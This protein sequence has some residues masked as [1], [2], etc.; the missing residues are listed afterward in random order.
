V[1][2]VA[3][4]WLRVLASSEQPVRQHPSFTQPGA[5][6][7]DGGT[8]AIAAV[9]R[10][11]L[12]AMWE[13]KPMAPPMRTAA[14]GEFALT[15]DIVGQ[16][17]ALAAKLLASL[18]DRWRHTIAV[19]GRAEEL[20][21]AVDPGDREILRAAAWLHDVG[22]APRIAVT[23]FH[24]LDGARFLDSQGWP[25]RLCALVAH[26]SGARFVARML[27]LGDQLRTYPDERSPVTDALVYADQTVGVRGE[28]LPIEERMADMLHRHGPDSPNAAAHQVRAPYLLAAAHRV[29]QRLRLTDL[30]HDSLADLAGFV[31]ARIAEEE[32]EWVTRV[33]TGGPGEPTARARLANCRARRENVRH[34]GRRSSLTRAADAREL[35]TLALPYYDHPDYEPRWLQPSTVL[36]P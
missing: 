10:R 35:E 12:P 16:A 22:Y 19:A 24:P 26:H 29:E 34:L 31:L 33:E 28:P 30:M 2:G 8:R 5:L 36:D 1:G 25:P 21:D 7:T 23:G 14:R 27:D 6:G 15:D 11:C 20:T 13:E 3:V 9:A 4:A 18:P 32:A 17:K